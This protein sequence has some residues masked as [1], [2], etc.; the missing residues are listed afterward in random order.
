MKLV[1]HMLV[2]LTVIGIVS[3]AVLSE[4]NSWAAP[5]IE[6]NRK[7]ETERAIFVV[8][9]DG[10]RYNKIENVE[11][12][13]YEVFDDNENSLGYAMPYEGNGFQGNIRL[14]VGIDKGMT[15]V[16]GL[17]VLEQVETPGLGTKVTEKPFTNQFIDIE[18]NP[19]IKW[20]KGAEP[21]A[22]NEIQ[23]ITGATISSKAI[24]RI[25]NEGMKKLRS[26]NAEENRIEQ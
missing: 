12:E 17:E 1:I 7:A 6:A 3:G 2:T 8:Q 26:V 9:S 10:K 20:V 23:A 18:V 4:L 15:K 11:F 24:V 16:L 19:E 13:L 22:S 25:I 5:K 14:I 21:Q